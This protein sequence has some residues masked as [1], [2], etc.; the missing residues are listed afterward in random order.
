MTSTTKISSKYQVVIPSEVRAGSNI[1]VGQTLH[2][3]GLENG[4]V[5][6][7][8]KSPME[9]AREYF[10]GKNVWDEDPVEV[11]KREGAAWDAKLEKLYD[12]LS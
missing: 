11:R 5:L 1:A 8:A 10:A 3:Y 12:R 4:D 7:S 9:R 2:V 6:L